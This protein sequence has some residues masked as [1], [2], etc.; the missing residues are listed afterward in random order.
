M[1][2]YQKR[3]YREAEM[4]TSMLWHEAL[5]KDIEET[6]THEQM[7]KVRK[8]EMQLMPELGIPFPSMFDTL[9]L[10]DEQKKEMN[11]IADE[12]KAEYEGLIREVTTLKAERIVSTYGL[13]K[14]K[15]FTSREEFDKSL[16]DIHR[17]YVPSEETRKKN[18]DLQER[19]TK[20]TS[21]LQNRLMNVLTDEQLD[22]MQ[23]IMDE[24]PRFVR[25][26]LVRFK[27]EREGQSKSPTYTPGPD[28]WRPGDPLPAQ[29][30][31]ERKRRPF[32]GT[33]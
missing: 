23:K 15:T 13:L 2:G 10:T 18:K 19:G 33:E 17:Q 24:S 12:M 3:V 31:E 6:L 25:Q 26:R 16:R 28:S 4:M 9:E 7:L 32:P 1:N 29:F 14:G 20:F 8:L 11:R 21:L 27:A 30:K 5:Q 22:M